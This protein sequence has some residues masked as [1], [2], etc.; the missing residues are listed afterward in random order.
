MSGIRGGGGCV[1]PQMRLWLAGV[2][3]GMLVVLTVERAHSEDCPA[4]RV[5]AQPY[6]APT[7]PATGTGLR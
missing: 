6:H 1:S 2:L 5:C 7:P 4:G 3:I